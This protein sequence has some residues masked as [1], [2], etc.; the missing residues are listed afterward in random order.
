MTQS[1][2]AIHLGGGLYL[3]SDGTLVQGAPSPGVPAYEAPFK[4]PIDPKKAADAMRDVQKALKDI[5]KDPDVLEK[6]AAFGLDTGILDVLSGVGK[7]AGAIAPVLAAASLV[8]ELLKLFGLFSDGESALQ[9]LIIQRFDELERNVESIKLLIQVKDLRTHRVAIESFLAHVG[10]YARQLQN[11]NPTLPQLEADRGRLFTEESSAAKAVAMLLDPDTWLANFDRDQ[12]KRVW[13]SVARL[14]H[15]LPGPVGAAPTKALFPDDG[16]LAF[17]HRLM[18]PL[19]AFA[20]EAYLTGIRGILPE[21]RS[22][23]EFRGILRLLAN[24]M[25]DLANGLR[26]FGLARTVYHKE[27]FEFELL[28]G[29][30]PVSVVAAPRPFLS[31]DCSLWP[32]GAMDLRY[33]DDSFFGPFLDELWRDEFLG[34]PHAT[35][36]GGMNLRWIP[37]ARLQYVGP[38]PGF[39]TMHYYRITNPEECAAA[40][41]QQ[42]EKDYA[43]LLSVSG[44]SELVRLSALL[45]NESTEPDKSQTVSVSKPQLLSAPQPQQTVTVQ[46]EPIFLAG[47]ISAEARREPR[48]CSATVSIGT[49]SLNRAR[50]V[51]YKVRLRTLRSFFTSGG[52]LVWREPSYDD[53][54]RSGYEED[55]TDP[56]CFQLVVQRNDLALDDALIVAGSSPREGTVHCEGTVTLKAHT[57]DWW[58]PVKPPFAIGAPIDTTLAALRGLGWSPLD[59]GAPPLG[60]GTAPTT[61]TPPNYTRLVPATQWIATRF[62]DLS[63]H[64]PWFS[65]APGE[66]AQHREP[67]EKAVRIDY[68]LDWHGD[69]MEVTVDGNPADRN[70]VVYAVIEERLGGG[71]LIDTAIALPLNGQVTFVSQKFFDEEAAA[72]AHAAST[73]GRFAERYR[74]RRRPG[75]ADPVV[76]WLRPGDLVSRAGLA[77][78]EALAREHA[79]DLLEATVAEVTG[80][81]SST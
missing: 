73:L 57:F 33:H 18:V 77:R 58:V 39:P 12:H 35:K 14:L 1:A 72:L 65:G 6:F 52:G 4:L 5:N 28:S 13:P 46:S 54:C 66:A 3:E 41:N 78:L 67:T 34:Y 51:E 7:I 79:N 15:T 20:V 16:S 2:F 80:L 55:P 17:D 27:D 48:R 29:G 64:F 76:G 68:R 43:D 47:A 44:Y 8:V 74:E 59:E 31:P 36:C 69:R 53:Y 50:S 24:K 37:P 21:Y 75:P 70:F 63:P 10:S 9:R 19:A 22:T 38:A 56:R 45:R 32:V 40:A 30:G 81:M 26:M 62:A 23:G 11:T 60:R 42:A 61:T 71:Q 49:Q 25:D